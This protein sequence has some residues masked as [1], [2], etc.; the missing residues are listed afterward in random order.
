MDNEMGF[1]MSLLLDG[2]LSATETLELW[3]TIEKDPALAD[4]WKRYNQI[5]SSMNSLPPVMAS[6]DLVN[7]VH[8]ALASEPTIVAP[9]NS[10][11]AKKDTSKHVLLRRTGMIA[12]SGVLALMV[13][14]GYQQQVQQAVNPINTQPTTA[15]LLT[16]NVV[17]TNQPQPQQI[18]VRTQPV[19]S[20]AS[21]VYSS[22]QIPSERAF[23]E[24]LE[25]HGEYAY[26]ISSQP[27]IPAARVVSYNTKTH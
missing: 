20:A 9:K 22:T 8:Q 23:N 26:S 5:R 6:P 18:E 24:Y 3:S 15:D 19:Q 25:T 1:K 4:Q 16:D 21:H 2:E 27:L 7:S 17:A 11:I 12:A 10:T 14:G 13:Y